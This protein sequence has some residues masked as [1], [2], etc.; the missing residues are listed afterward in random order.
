[1]GIMRHPQPERSTTADW[2]HRSGYQWRWA[3][4][5]IAPGSSEAV[6]PTEVEQNDAARGGEQVR[7]GKIAALVVVPDRFSAALLTA[8]PINAIVI[9]DPNQ[10]AGQTAQ[11]ALSAAS[12]RLMGAI[13]AARLS[14]ADHPENF[15]T[16][17][18]AALAAWRKPSIGVTVETMNAPK[19]E[20]PSA[21]RG[22]AQ[23]SPGMLVQFT[24][25]GL[26]TTATILVM[27]QDAH[28]AAH[29]HHIDAAL[30]NHR[31]PCSRCSRC[32]AAANA[33]HRLRA[34]VPER[35]LSRPTAGDAAGDGLIRRVDCGAG[36]V[37]QHHRQDRRTGRDV[38]AA[39]DV[40]PTAL[41]GA[42][43]P[44]DM[45]GPAFNTIGHLTPGAWAMDG[46]QNIVVRGLGLA[47]VLVP[48][49]VLLGFAA[50]FF[51]LAV[52]RLKF[53]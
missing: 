48:A 23:S 44:L 31:G 4:N 50:L 33:A 36:L 11:T 30:G 32:A 52:W 24:I 35:Q 27:A 16:A 39:G 19:E 47:S 28:V 1:M 10:P 53:E 2:I 34:V 29:A 8:E 18:S 17:L 15:N 25:F 49:I 46:F 38:V 3:Q 14:T 37:H 6:H 21:L 40:H 7:D 9:V 26:T 22:F 51:G 45:T 42:W 41:A 12:G 13:E 43:F 5:S 20:T